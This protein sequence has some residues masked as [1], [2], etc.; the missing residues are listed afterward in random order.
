MWSL[1]LKLWS[2]LPRYVLSNVV[3]R[4]FQMKLLVWPA[5]CALGAGQ[6]CSRLLEIGSVTVARSASVGTRVELTC[7]DTWRKPSHDPKKNVLFLTMGPPS[8]APY[9]LRCSG[10]FL[11]PALFV[12]K[13]AASNASLRK[14]S[15]AEPWN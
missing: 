14:N 10:F 15:K 12:K 1:S 7:G 6:N 13:S 11:A 5:R 2:T 3:E 9:W 4:T 8:V